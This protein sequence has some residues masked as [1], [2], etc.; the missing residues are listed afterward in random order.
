MIDHVIYKY[1][2]IIHATE[3]TPLWYDEANENETYIEI[4]LKH[5]KHI[6]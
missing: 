1:N 6:K 5:Q 2:F 4:F 3:Y